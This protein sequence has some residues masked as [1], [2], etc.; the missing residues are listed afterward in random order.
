MMTPNTI[1]PEYLIFHIATLH[2]TFK[3]IY[4]NAFLDEPLGANPDEEEHGFLHSIGNFFG[5]IG[6]GIKKA[7]TWV[8]ETIK[9]PFT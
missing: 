9:S 3:R 7:A 4:L 8:W 5:S 1:K 2:A 6:R